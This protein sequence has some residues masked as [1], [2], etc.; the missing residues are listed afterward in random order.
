MQAAP[1]HH[2][3]TERIDRIL[4]RGF[5]WLRFPV[6][7][8]RQFLRDTVHLRKRQFL[9]SGL[10]SLLVYN[11]FLVADYLLVPE[12]FGLAVLLRLFVFTPLSII[13]WC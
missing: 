11:G 6:D 2:S 5:P 3:P 7:L 4:E 9:I 10:V 12:A 1:L 13:F 8:E